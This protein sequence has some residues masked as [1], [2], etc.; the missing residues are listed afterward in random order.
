MNYIL[1]IKSHDEANDFIYAKKAETKLTFAEHI[2]RRFKA[3][4]QGW[5]KKALLKEI[6]RIP[7]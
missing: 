3:K 1:Y 4:Q 7:Q 5:T 6:E 2:M